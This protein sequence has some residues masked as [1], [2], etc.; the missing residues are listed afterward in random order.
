[1]SFPGK[2]FFAGGHYLG[3]R[4]PVL[5]NEMDV[6]IPATFA[7]LQAWMDEHGVTALGR[8]ILVC[9]RWDLVKGIGELTAALPVGDGTVKSRHL[10]AKFGTFDIPACNAEI[11]R[12]TGPYA[13]L[14][15]AWAAAMARVAAFKYR[16]D[17]SIDPFEVYENDPATLPKEEL[18]AA[19]Y[20]PLK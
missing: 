7:K 14:S 6:T 3:I 15:N 9:H 19:V 2:V 20:L 10:P 12:H 8:R 17:R 18:V 11:V 1:L 5:I 13:Y 4:G 16:S